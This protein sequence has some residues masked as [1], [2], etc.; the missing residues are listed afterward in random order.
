VAALTTPAAVKV[1]LGVAEDE[2]A[3]DAMLTQ[4]IAW[5]SA[6][7]E[8]QCDRTFGVATYTEF[9][10]G[11]DQPWIVLKN[12]PVRIYQ[13]T[14]TL[15][16]GSATI[17]ALSD[18]NGLATGQPVVA[19]AAIPDNGLP[20][21]PVLS[22]LLSV[23]SSGLSAVMSAAATVSGTFTLSFGVSVLYD[24]SAAYGQAPMGFAP[25]TLLQPGTDWAL[26]IDQ[27]DGVTSR[28]GM[29]LN[30]DFGLWPKQTFWTS[31]LISGGPGPALGTIKVHYQA[32][33]IAVP[34]PLSM[35]VAEAAI[36][37]RK[38]RLWGSMLQ[39]EGYEEYNAAVL[40][41]E[42]PLGY[43]GGDLLPLIARYRNWPV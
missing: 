14:G 23:N 35:L 13:K 9:L 42:S 32:G 29:I 39:S 25:R 28:S 5:L 37:V 43:L 8:E 4:V 3:D 24:E 20:I 40:G 36:K 38:S 21:V 27:P 19:V 10:S 2:T 30:L 7:V 33:Y 17:T 22:T 18:V 1:L 16:S 31:G 12:R 26:K 6:A 34:A 15:T 11:T 41:K